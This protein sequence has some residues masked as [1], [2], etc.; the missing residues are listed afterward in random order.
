VTWRAIN[1]RI[2]GAEIRSPPSG[3]YEWCRQDNAIVVVYRRRD[4]ANCR[5]H[6]CLNKRRVA[7]TERKC[8]SGPKPAG[9]CILNHRETPE[10][11][12]TKT[13]RQANRTVGEVQI[14]LPNWALQKRPAGSDI[15]TLDAIKDL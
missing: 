11:K 7:K 1:G 2:G 9:L 5:A 4:T 13:S 8:S 6:L 10:R 14:A 15:S 3:S 12:I